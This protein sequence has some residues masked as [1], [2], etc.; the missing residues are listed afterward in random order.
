MFPLMIV[1]TTAVLIVCTAYLVDLFKKRLDKKNKY[2]YYLID[3]D[4][5]LTFLEQLHQKQIDIF[6][7]ERI[8][9]GKYIIITKERWNV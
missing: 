4:I 1:L 2:S 9:L 6:Y 5:I 3:K 7:F 8:D